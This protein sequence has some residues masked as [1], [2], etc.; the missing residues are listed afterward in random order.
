MQELVCSSERSSE[1]SLVRRLV[2]RSARSLLHG[3]QSP[4]HL[5]VLSILLGV[6]CLVPLGEASADRIQIEFD[7][8]SESFISL[9]GG[10][11]VTPPDGSL[12]TGSLRLQVD[13]SSLTSVIPEGEVIVDQASFSGT[14]SKNIAG[15]A[16]ISAPYSGNQVGSI[17]GVLDV[18]AT[19]ASFTEEMMLNLDVI[20]GCTGAAC[21]TL[22]LPMEVH[23]I[24]P[25]ALGFIAVEGLEQIGG[26]YIE[27]SAPIEL[28]GLLGTLNLVGIESSRQFV[29]PEPQAGSL[30]LLGLGVVGWCR[31]RR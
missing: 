31:N 23:G 18:G 26:A 24:Y 3:L 6:S 14:I 10:T 25:L 9:L 20:L 30:I 27:A 8:Q 5:G 21:A 4:L 28:A 29:V 17:S 7:F 19:G 15:L 22:G 1:R 13:A 2:P 16:D 11:I 12:D